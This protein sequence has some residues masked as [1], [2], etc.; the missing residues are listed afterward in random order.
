MQFQNHSEVK[1][2]LCATLRY[3]MWVM[4]WITVGTDHCVEKS[5][6]VIGPY[7]PFK[8]SLKYTIMTSVDVYESIH[9]KIIIPARFE[10]VSYLYKKKNLIFLYCAKPH[11]LEIH[12][13]S[14]AFCDVIEGKNKHNNTQH[15]LITITRCTC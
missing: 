5:G 2:C 10:C 14:F 3:H 4:P 1:I 12:R 13:S 15:H 7:S 11:L 9:H 8:G 6:Y